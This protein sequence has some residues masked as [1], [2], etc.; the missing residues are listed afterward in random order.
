ML[1][2]ASVV[3]ALCA[4]ALPAVA[5]P[6]EDALDG[7]VFAG[8]TGTNPGAIT[9][10]PASLLRI[11]PGWH[12]FLGGA[13]QLTQHHIERDVVGL[14]GNLSPGADVRASTMG[15]GGQAGFVFAWPGGMVAGAAAIQP[16][17]E[18]LT[19]QDALA[20]H[21]R[22]TRS[23][24]IDWSIGGGYRYGSYVHVAF[25]ASVSDRSTTL[26]FAR[27]TALEAGRD[28]A[29]GV[30]SDCGGSPCGLEHPLATER[31]SI[32]GDRNFLD[33]GNLLLAGG[34]LVRLP[35]DTLVGLSY[36]RPWQLGAYELTGTVKVTAAPRDGGGVRTG[37][38]T[39]FV[40]LPE[41]WRVGTRT[42][43]APGWEV[44]TELRWRRLGGIGTYDIR[45]H[46]GDLA[47]GGVPEYYPRARGL[48][49][50]V[51]V[52]VGAEQVDHGQPLLLGARVGGDSGASKGD[53]LSPTSPWGPQLNASLGLQLRVASRWVVQ[54][55][56]RL[57]YQA[58]VEARP[59]AYD[60]IDRIECVESGYALELPACESVRDGYGLPTAGGRYGR[61]D[62]VG[63][64]GL[65]IEVR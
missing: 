64:L 12:V 19:G 52:E 56:Y 46:G 31:W 42:L 61:F 24:R 5:S 27:D 45:T 32:V 4:T 26:A 35:R 47:G 22:G 1:A 10:N 54:A 51:A 13:G 43:V 25:S 55:G 60:P 65:R 30:T 28:P 58:R 18:T 11:S 14:D 36:Q 49:D 21:S 57:G 44:V 20:Y 40:G 15:A 37:D 7:A 3:I 33:V 53:R 16:P 6:G 50:A 41:V 63:W 38:A 8:P 62:H 59:S 39:V 9:S 17:E 34:L 29:R 48:S 23:R 2:R